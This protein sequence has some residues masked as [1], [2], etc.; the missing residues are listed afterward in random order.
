MF[1]VLHS[2]SISDVQSSPRKVTLKNDYSVT[3]RPR[4]GKSSLILDKRK[5]IEMQYLGKW[6]NKLKEKKWWN[7]GSGPF[8]ILLIGK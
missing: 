3:L 6:I 2:L 1:I 4:L 7:T 5:Q 8:L